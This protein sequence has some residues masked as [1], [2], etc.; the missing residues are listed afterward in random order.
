MKSAVKSTFQLSVKKAIFNE[1]LETPYQADFTVLVYTSAPTE[2][3]CLQW[4]Q[5][6]Y[7]YTTNHETK[8]E[9]DFEKYIHIDNEIF[10]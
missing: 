1:T 8:V 6:I 5:F 9:M 10:K 7:M 2:S 4:F 3:N